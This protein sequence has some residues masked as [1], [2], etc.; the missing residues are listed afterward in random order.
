MTFCLAPFFHFSSI[1]QKCFNSCCELLGRRLMPDLFHL[2]TKAH[3]PV[4]CLSPH[5]WFLSESWVPLLCTRRVSTA[6][7]STNWV[8]VQSNIINWY[9]ERATEWK[10]FPHPRGFQTELELIQFLDHWFSSVHI[11]QND[12]EVLFKTQ[13]IGPHSQKF[14]F[15]KFGLGLKNMHL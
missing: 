7:K 11:H 4:L 1:V 5:L 8:K 6:W 10:T 9:K 15:S 13:V 12:P 2:C 3:V 14:W